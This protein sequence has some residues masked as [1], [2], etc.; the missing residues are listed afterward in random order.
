MLKKTISCTLLIFSVFQLNAQFFDGFGLFVG[1]TASKHRFVNSSSY[2]AIFLT[3][4]IPVPTHKSKELF[5]FSVGIFKEFL[6]FKHFKWQTEIEYC[7]KGAIEKIFTTNQFSEISTSNK[8]INL[9]WNNFIKL[10]GNEGYR[11]IPYFMIG[12]RLDYNL[13]R[14]LTTYNEIT[15]LV[16]KIKVSP[17]L[18]I[19]Y[20]FVNYG[21]WRL[22]TE[23]H[24][25]PDI[26][27]I[28]TNNIIFSQRMWELRVGIVGRIDKSEKCNTPKYN[29][30]YY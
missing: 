29:G 5:F 3:H 26:I 17:D 14:K 4:T 2:D 9:E 27:K 23:G 15:N 10:K 18:G 11:G 8:Y 25:N 1:G 24:Y 7:R 21:N 6:S 30:S 22:F 13:T 20:E 28:R 16:P 19:G 12:F